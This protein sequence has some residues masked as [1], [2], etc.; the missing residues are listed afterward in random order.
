MPQE[1]SDYNYDYKEMLRKTRII[2][3]V[4]QTALFHEIRCVG[5]CGIQSIM[6][7]LPAVLTRNV[8]RERGFVF[9]V[10]K[11]KFTSKRLYLRRS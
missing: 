4:T 6:I 7:F 10:E 3:E 2:R 11:P 5:G 9:H 1:I 8:F